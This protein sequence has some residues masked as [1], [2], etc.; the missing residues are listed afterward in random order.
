[1]N[2]VITSFNGRGWQVYGREFIK[3]FRQFWP[4]V[5]LVVYYEGTMPNI[6]RPENEIW[7]DMFDAADLRDFLE[8]IERMPC[9][10]GNFPG[11]YD[12]NYDARMARKTFIQAHAAKEYGGKIFWLDADSITHATVPDDFL[13][14]VLPDDKLCCFL[15]REGWYY[16]ESGFIGFNTQHPDCGRF[17]HAYTQMFLSGLI[18]VQRR[19]HDCEAFDVVRHALNKPDAFHNL[20]PG[21][22][23]GTMHPFVNSVLGSYMDHKKG[24]RKRSRSTVKDLVTARQEDY[25]TRQDNGALI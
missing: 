12:I 16:T 7:R 11:K 13:D 2:T 5:R 3:T 23:K 19:W 20:C 24:P 4:K 1:M 10:C 8:T 22:P 15:S 21:I 9:L 14:T 25:W 17:F 18:F 6:Q